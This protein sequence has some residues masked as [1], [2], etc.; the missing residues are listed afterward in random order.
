M[1]GRVRDI[2]S[3]MRLRLTSKAFRR[4]GPCLLDNENHKFKEGEN[5]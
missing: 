2:K 4:V 1:R 3:I 5:I